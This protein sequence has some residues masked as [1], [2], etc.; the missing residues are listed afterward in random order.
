MMF[1]N[2]LMIFHH[3]FIII[4]I[5]MT[6]QQDRLAYLHWKE[7]ILK[8]CE[9]L[10]R[11]LSTWQLLQWP[12]AK[13]HHTL[14]FQRVDGK[15]LWFYRGF[16]PVKILWLWRSWLELVSNKQ[17][18][19]KMNPIYLGHVPNGTQIVTPERSHVTRGII[20]L[21]ACL[22]WTYDCTTESLITL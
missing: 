13:Y 17:H 16:V 22:R 20:L 18:M 2:Y 1:D 8:F 9:Q 4:T 15:R 3:V 19:C 5:T 12:V 21:S 6:K 10:H 7:T 14:T 11:K